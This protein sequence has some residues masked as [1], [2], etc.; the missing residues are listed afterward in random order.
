[1]PFV[2]ALRQLQLR[3]GPSNFCL[4]HVSMVPLVS[5]E[6][7]TKP[8]QHSVKELRALGLTPDFIVCRSSHPLEQGA[9]DK[10]ALFC[11]LPAE[12]VL[13]IPDLPNIFHVPL[14]LLEQS[15]H[16]HLALRLLFETRK[17]QA[18][19]AAAEEVEEEEEEE[20]PNGEFK[21]QW[22]GLVDAVDSASDPVTVALVG[23]YTEQQD[24]YLSVVA[25]LR[26]R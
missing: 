10:I 13:S 9:R 19:Q 17:K 3:V 25:A 8:T 6:Q 7:K 18:V 15:F 24:A 14:R 2:E 16:R 20:L 21:R 23:K 5:G 12:R 1:M 26:H 11:N 22:A 4:L